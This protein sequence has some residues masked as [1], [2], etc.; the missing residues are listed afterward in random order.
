MKA[1]AFSIL[2]LMA[3]LSPVL[4]LSQTLTVNSAHTIAGGHIGVLEVQDGAKIRVTGDVSIANAN[5]NNKH[6]VSFVVSPGAKLSIGPLNFN[7]KVTFTN[8]GEVLSASLEMQNGQNDFY[9]Y[10]KHNV[11]G[12][13][14]L[15]SGQ[16]EYHN[17]G[18]LNVTNFTNLHSGRLTLCNCGKLQTYG[19]NV[20][21]T[22][23]I[24]GK[25]HIYVTNTLNLNGHLT[26]SP[27]ITFWFA[28][29][30]NDK[31]KLGAAKLTDTPTC[32]PDP[33]PVRYENLKIS[34]F[35]DE[36]GNLKGEISFKVTENSGLLKMKLMFSKDGK[37]WIV[38]F[39]EQPAAL[40]VGKVYTKEFFLNLK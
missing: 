29:P 25:G 14:Q 35:Y 38:N 31:T 20:N 5:W 12:D 7:G 2:F 6:D 15:T 26:K 27:D 18:E 30:I 33:M 36:K 39:S 3:V 34:T 23:K 19:L 9:N 1:R 21:G 8:W 32:K 16:S 24:D 40:V 11:M 10:G 4:G 37:T 28:G 17:C 22:D 13:A